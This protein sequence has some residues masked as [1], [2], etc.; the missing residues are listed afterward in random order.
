VESVA[1][2]KDDTFLSLVYVVDSLVIIC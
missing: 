2:S 1:T